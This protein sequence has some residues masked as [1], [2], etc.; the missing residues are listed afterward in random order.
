[1]DLERISNRKLT[2]FL[3]RF[4]RTT[5]S[6]LACNRARSGVGPVSPLCYAYNCT[7]LLQL[8]LLFFSNSWL[9]ISYLQCRTARS[10]QGKKEHF[11]LL[12]YSIDLRFYFAWQKE[13]Q[14]IK[15]AALGFDFFFKFSFF[16]SWD[17]NIFQ[18]VRFWFQTLLFQVSFLIIMIKKHRYWEKEDSHLY[19]VKPSFQWIFSNTRSCWIWSA[20]RL[21]DA[22]IDLKLISL[23]TVIGRPEVIT[24][25]SWWALHMVYW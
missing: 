23:R 16:M 4:E 15:Q 6:T 13:S 20:W 2:F 18:A 9:N 14:E 19:I 25:L 11:I 8:L 7:Y 21:I 12:V 10:V 3:A 5:E 17:T 22:V 1:M 24:Q